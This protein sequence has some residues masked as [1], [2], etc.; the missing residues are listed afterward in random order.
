L[1]KEEVCGETQGEVSH[2]K[3]QINLLHEQLKNQQAANMG[4]D[5]RQGEL[6]QLRNENHVLKQQ[7]NLLH[8]QLP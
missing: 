3:E 7:I 5:L 1:I 8:K 4:V 6:T 2:V